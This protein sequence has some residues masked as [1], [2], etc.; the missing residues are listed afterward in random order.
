[1]T[2]KPTIS[3]EQ[4]LKHLNGTKNTKKKKA[5]S[6]PDGK[7]IV[8]ETFLTQLKLRQLPLPTRELQF[9]LARKW[10]FDFAWEELKIAVEI[11]GGIQSKGRHVR[12]EGFEN[13]ARK[14]NAAAMMGWKVLR[15][16]SRMVSNGEAIAFIE[17][18][19]LK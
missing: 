4:L 10:R 17:E 13:D 5:T 16:S 9:D 19:I 6:S 8:E 12:P 15:F 2:T 1:M 18:R 3:K 11:E 14:Y 7:S